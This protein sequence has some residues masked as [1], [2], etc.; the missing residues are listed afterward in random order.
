MKKNLLVL[1][2]LWAFLTGF[3]S[4]LSAQ[5][6]T[7]QERLKVASQLEI[8]LRALLDQLKVVV[9]PPTAPKPA[10]SDTQ[11]NDT[12]TLVDMADP[13]CAS[14]D[15]NDETNAP[16]P[17]KPQCNDTFDNDGDGKVDGV[18]PG[19]ADLTDNDETDTVVPPSDGSFPVDPVVLEDFQVMKIPYPGVKFWH[20][21]MGGDGVSSDGENTIENGILTMRAISGGYFQNYAYCQDQN[22][23]RWL[24]ECQSNGT[25]TKIPT[26]KAKWPAGMNRMRLWAIAP[27]GARNTYPSGQENSQLG[28]YIRAPGSTG[29]ESDNGHYYH[30]YNLGGTEYPAGLVWQISVDTFPDHQRGNSGGMEVGDKSFPYPNCGY[31]DCMTTFY[32]DWPYAGVPAGNQ[33]QFIDK[34]TLYSGKE[35]ADLMRNVRSFQSAYHAATNTIYLGW[36]RRKDNSGLGYTVRYS[37]SP[38]TNFASATLAGT[39]KSPDTDAYNKVKFMFKLPSAP[40]GS[41]LW[42]AVQPDGRTDFRQEA[43]KLK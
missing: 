17:P 10:C 35:A 25:V 15:D 23:W 27:A 39:F 2:L 16:P 1:T 34:I 43:V 7:D 11:D 42:V 20:N 5:T 8:Q 14:P 32:I 6:M 36:S 31:F 19:C 13:G 26:G 18:D 4:T 21:Q 12:D 24:W 40:A 41:T 9:N 29:M 38:I 33:L 22:V 28:T 30:N 3:G 37:Y